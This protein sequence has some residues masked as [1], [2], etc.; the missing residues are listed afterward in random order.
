MA[1]LKHSYLHCGSL[2]SVVRQLT[3]LEGGEIVAEIE[4]G[5]T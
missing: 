5:K 1:S 3:M 2:V 4:E